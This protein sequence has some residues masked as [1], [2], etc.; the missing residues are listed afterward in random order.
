MN[1]LAV[2]TG[3]SQGIG[4][5][6]AKVFG[7]NGFDLVINSETD[8]V[9]EAESALQDLGY[10]VTAIKADLSTREGADDF[11][12]R[13][14]ELGGSLHSVVIN[15]GFGVGGSFLETDMEKEIRMMN[16]NMV[17][18][19]YL[20]KKFLQVMNQRGSG[21]LLLTSSVAGEMPGPYYAVYAATKAY[22]Q[23]FAEAIRHEVSELA[24]HITVTALQPGATDTNF[25]ARAGMEN[26]AAGKG[27]KD[28]PRKVALA[29]YEAL[30]KG[31]DHVVVGL[32][33]KIMTTTGKVLPQTAQAAAQGKMAKPKSLQQ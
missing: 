3:S 27:E 24:S 14:V 13:T 1:K 7:E 23:S 33:N 12:Q 30:M 25:F 6:L 9:F 10:K 26:T 18:L 29:G 15:A 19:T 17:Y 20:T 22:V 4:F 31:D 32:K 5:E 11:F 8:L 21:R 2:V 16:L 28:D